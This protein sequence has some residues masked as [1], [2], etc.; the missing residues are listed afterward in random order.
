M[1]TTIKVSS[2]TKEKLKDW[3]REYGA[4]SL[5]ELLQSLV[6]EGRDLGAAA[7]ANGDD[8]DGEE[9][10]VKR[11]KIDVREPLY[12]LDLLS[13]REGMLQCLTGFTRVDIDLL[14][15]R[16]RE[17]SCCSTFFFP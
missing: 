2:E 6:M 13:E 16:F 9:E 11:R 3:K 8:K 12:S 1:S 4:S 10:L 17:V 15:R 5:D 14:V 7:A